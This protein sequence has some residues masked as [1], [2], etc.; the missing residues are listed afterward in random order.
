VCGQSTA[1]KDC[2]TLAAIVADSNARL[3]EVQDIE[4]ARVNA[5][6]HW[7][8]EVLQAAHGDPASTAIA[9]ER[10]YPRGGNEPQAVRGDSNH[11][12]DLAAAV[13]RVSALCERW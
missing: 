3:L 12:L 8:R 4:T 9:R 1:A 7:A 10:G 6:S 5:I 11:G 2:K 13:A